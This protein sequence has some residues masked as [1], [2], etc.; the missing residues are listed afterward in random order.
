MS[1]EIHEDYSYTYEDCIILYEETRKIGSI[2]RHFINKSKNDR[3]IQVAKEIHKRLSNI[4]EETI[5]NNYV[6]IYNLINC[7]LGYIHHKDLE[8]I[9]ISSQ[10]I[11]LK[12]LMFL[13]E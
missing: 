2:L 1:I 5:I 10:L 6:K 7:F 13:Y 3:V 11:E 4:H 8:N 12:N 9:F